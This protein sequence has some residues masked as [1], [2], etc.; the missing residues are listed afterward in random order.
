M[1]ISSSNEVLI[2][3]KSKADPSVILTVDNQIRSQ[4]KF[5]QWSFG[6]MLLFTVNAFINSL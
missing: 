2:F 5:F 3:A 6:L 4:I 1:I